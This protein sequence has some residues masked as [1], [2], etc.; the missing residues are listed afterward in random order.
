M[1][2]LAISMLLVLAFG[3]VP[4]HTYSKGNKT[5]IDARWSF[6][7]GLNYNLPVGKL[8][9]PATFDPEFSSTTTLVGGGFSYC[10]SLSYSLRF[11][12][13]QSISSNGMHE[14]TAALGYT[15]YKSVM[16]FHDYLFTYHGFTYTQHT[17]RYIFDDLNLELRLAYRFR[18]DRTSVQLGASGLLHSSRVFREYLLDGSHDSSSSS[19]WWRL[20]RWLPTVQV[21][22]RILMKGRIEFEGF[23]SGDK[24]TWPEDST[25]WWDVQ[26]GIQASLVKPQTKKKH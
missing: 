13:D 17:D 11:G 6:A 10:P 8:D 7:V 24:R 25:Y 22:Y 3:L 1:N 21:N 2:R 9:Y 12:Y 4:Q 18:K 5:K 15:D 19:Y 23:V 16:Q 20:R 26:V 14:F